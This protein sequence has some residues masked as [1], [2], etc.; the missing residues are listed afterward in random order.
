MRELRRCSTTAAWRAPGTEHPPGRPGDRALRGASFAPEPDLLRPERDRRAG[1]RGRLQRGRLDL[2]RARRGQPQVRA[3]DPVHRQAQPQ[4]AADLPQQVRPGPVRERAARLGDGRASA[5][6]RRSTSAVRSRRARFRR[7]ARP[8]RT[9]TSSACSRCSGAT[10][11]TRPS[12]QDVDYHV[13]ADLTGQANHLGVTIQADI[14]KQ[15]LP[16][17]NNGYGAV[18]S[19]RATARPHRRSTASSPA[20]PDRPHPLPGGQLLHGPRGPDQLRRRLLRRDRPGR[21]RAHRGD[22]QARRRHGPDQRPQGL[23]APDGRRASRSS[24]RSRTCTSP[25]T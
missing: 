14:I 8:S 7:S 24:T 12:R 4:R 21:G 15:K 19:R 25:R 1:D 10:C 9:R 13:A 2:R 5:S 18:N 16:E 23:P 11:A 3:P 20:T 17:N 6:A 22:Q